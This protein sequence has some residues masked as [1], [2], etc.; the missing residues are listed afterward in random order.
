[1]LHGGNS[2][3]LTLN[4]DDDLL[5]RARIRALELHTSVNAVV[6]EYLESF[7]DTDPSR[8][9][10]DEFLALA[11]QSQASSGSEGRDWRRDGL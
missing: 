10:L 6:R 2:G 1:M 9:A 5:H 3:W 4:L 7:A 8:Q 11:R